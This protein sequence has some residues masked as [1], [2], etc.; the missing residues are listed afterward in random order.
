M[1]S[2]RSSPVSGQVLPGDHEPAV[3]TEQG[4]DLLPIGIVAERVGLSRRQLSQ[5]AKEGKLASYKTGREYLVSLSEAERHATRPG[6]RRGRPPARRVDQ[7][8]P[9]SPKIAS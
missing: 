7:H 5:L 9:S 3:Y 1:Q 4:I 8:S 6:P 2:P